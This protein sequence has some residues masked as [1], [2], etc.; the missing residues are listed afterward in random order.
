LRR[1]PDRTLVY[2]DQYEERLRKYAE[3]PRPEPVARPAGASKFYSDKRGIPQP[4]FP[5]A[6][7]GRTCAAAPPL[8]RTDRKPPPNTGNCGL[9][10]TSTRHI[11]YKA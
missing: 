11:A 3:R 8:H 1:L 5:G 2:A 9:R 6:R 7:F 10:W 4:W